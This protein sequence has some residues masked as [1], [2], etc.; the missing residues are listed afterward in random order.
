[1]VLKV[2]FS[3]IPIQEFGSAVPTSAVSADPL[4]SSSAAMQARP[5]SMVRVPEM[6]A[7]P[8]PSTSTA[9]LPAVSVLS[10]TTVV[11]TATTSTASNTARHSTTGHSRNSSW[12]LRV[13]KNT[14]VNCRIHLDR[15]YFKSHPSSRYYR[16]IIMATL[17]QLR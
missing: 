15:I 12:D 8:L 11:S 6:N 14:Q 16:D 1:M 5:G 2:L 7:A 17:E 4:A 9:A 3:D 13:S 10:A